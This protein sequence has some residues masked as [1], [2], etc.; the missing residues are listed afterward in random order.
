MIWFLYA[1]L[2]MKK[3]NLYHLC[4]KPWFEKILALPSRLMA[5]FIAPFCVHRD[6]AR[7]PY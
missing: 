7:N 3:R 4:Q 2:L 1:T 6:R 5:F